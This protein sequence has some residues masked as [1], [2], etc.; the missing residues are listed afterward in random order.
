MNRL[1]RTF[2]LLPALII[3]LVVI[4]TVTF[5]AGQSSESSFWTELLSFGAPQSIALGQ[6]I[7]PLPTPTTSTVPLPTNTPGGTVPMPTAT[8]TRP[9]VVYPTATPYHRPGRPYYPPAATATARPTVTATP[10]MADS[11]PRDEAYINGARLDKVIGSRLSEVI[12]GYTEDGWLYRSNNNGTIWM[13]IA[14]SPAVTDF[15]FNVDNPDVIYGTNG[16]DCTDDSVNPIYKSV[17]G[18]RTWLELPDSADKLPLLTNPSNEDML[19][20]ADCGM[21]YLSTDGGMTWAEKPDLSP[22]ALWSSF[23][24]I[25]MAAAALVGAGTDEEPNWDQ[26]YAGGI[27]EEGTG[28]IAFSNDLGET[29]VRLTPNIDPAPWSLTA[30]TANPYIEGQI[31]FVEP[32]SVWFTENFGV[33]WQV[34][35][36]GLNNVLDRGVSGAPFGLNAIVYHNESDTLYLATARG[37]YEKSPTG[38][39]WSKIEDTSFDLAEITGIV[40]TTGTSDMIWLNSDDGVYIY[41]VE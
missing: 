36:K 17:D 37:L 7:S 39:T 33:N 2:L 9:V 34:T 15:I 25:D 3:A 35:T 22:D 10:I 38:N 21:L 6:T 31:G 1:M 32:R 8:P 24:V 26:L 18:G 29:W 11:D 13:L 5:S 40:L 12:Y 41:E 19:F 16:V 14:Q 27:N 28:V 20:A 30:I 4:P 23:R